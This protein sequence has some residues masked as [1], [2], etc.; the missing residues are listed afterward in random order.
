MR[1]IACLLAWLVAAGPARAVVPPAPA[2]GGGSHAAARLCRPA[3]D[4][5]ERR[6]GIPAGLLQAV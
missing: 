1:A 4:L 6:H 5:A 3:I 2:P